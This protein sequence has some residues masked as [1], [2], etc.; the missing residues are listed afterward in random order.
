MGDEILEKIR[1]STNKGFVI[2]NEKFIV[3]IEKLLS[4][5]SLESN[6]VGKITTGILGRRARK[7]S[8]LI[9]KVASKINVVGPLF[10]YII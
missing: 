7:T 3:Q 5:V 10:H 6:I 9:V 2:G 4:V 8:I 1:I